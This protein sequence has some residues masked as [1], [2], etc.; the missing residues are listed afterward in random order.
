[1]RH[2]QWTKELA[3]EAKIAIRNIRRDGN[4]SADH[5]QKEK[6]LT[7]DERDELK[8]EIQDLTKKY[9]NQ[10]SEHAKSKEA[11]VMDE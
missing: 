11:E 8:K 5:E 6:I 3:E 4:K 2:P 7:E 9:E 10:A 1:M